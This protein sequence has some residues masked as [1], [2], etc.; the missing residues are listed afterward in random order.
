[1]K[2]KITGIVLV[3]IIAGVFVFTR[4]KNAPPSDFRDAVVSQD[5][6]TTIPSFENET[7]NIPVP[8]ASVY[9][10]AKP[11]STIRENIPE[12]PLSHFTAG[13]SLYFLNDGT[14]VYVPKE[15]T[16]VIKPISYFLVNGS[17]AYV[18]NEDAQL[19]PISYFLNNGKGD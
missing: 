1:M 7:D 13:G 10:A 6:D 16:S 8:K 5:F 14:S 12:K 2:T 4:T 17:P 11:V 18:V 19:V 9:D 15:N 3:T